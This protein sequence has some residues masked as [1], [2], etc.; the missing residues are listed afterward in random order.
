MQRGKWLYRIPD[1]YPDMKPKG[2]PT[3]PK[4]YFATA[5]VGEASWVCEICGAEVAR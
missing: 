2:Y 1:E 5:E 3:N 4:K